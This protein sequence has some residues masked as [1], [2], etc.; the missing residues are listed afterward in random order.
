VIHTLWKAIFV[1]PWDSISD[2]ACEIKGSI[3]NEWEETKSFWKDPE[4]SSTAC[5]TASEASKGEQ[6]EGTGLPSINRLSNISMSKFGLPRLTT[7]EDREDLGGNGFSV[8]S[9]SSHPSV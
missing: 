6:N 8:H 1:R 7:E 2:K 3:R 9:N 4:C 5:E